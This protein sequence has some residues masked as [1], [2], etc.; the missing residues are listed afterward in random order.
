MGGTRREEREEDDEAEEVRGGLGRR[1]RAARAL[2]CLRAGLRETAHRRTWTGRYAPTW[3]TAPQHRFWK[4]PGLRAGRDTRSRVRLVGDDFRFAD[5]RDVRRLAAC[6]IACHPRTGRERG[7]PRG[8][9]TARVR[10]SKQLQLSRCFCLLRFRWSTPREYFASLANASRHSRSKKTHVFG[11]FF[12]YADNF[13]AS[14]N[15]WVGG[16]VARRALKNAVLQAATNAV[17]ASSFAASLPPAR[18]DVLSDENK[19]KTYEAL[20]AARRDARAARRGSWVCTTTPSP[21]RVPRTSRRTI[22]RSRRELRRRR[23]E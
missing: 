21:G 14:E 7:G 11:A 23:G 4:R 6:F 8:V 19:R 13:P 16:Y 3:W 15:A 2:A 22:S 9:A 20:A 5:G 18:R 17:V 1:A 12:P 10:H